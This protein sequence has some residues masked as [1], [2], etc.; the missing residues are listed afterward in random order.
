MQEQL[1]VT[2]SKLWVMRSFSRSPRHHNDVELEAFGSQ[3]DVL[4]VWLAYPTMMS[5]FN[6]VLISLDFIEHKRTQEGMGV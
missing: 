1:I 2:C 3:D 5:T 6:S 4:E